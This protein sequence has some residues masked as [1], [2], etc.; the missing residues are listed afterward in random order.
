MCK[1]ICGFPGV[2]KT[3]FYE[4][5]KHKLKIL[6]LDS[7]QFDKSNFP[8]NYI[9]ELKNAINNYDIIMISTH[10]EVLDALNNENIKFVSIVP[11]KNNLENYKNMYIKRGNT[12]EFIN[13]IE[14]NW[15]SFIES[16]TEH[17]NNVIELKNGQYLEDV[18]LN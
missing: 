12:K 18:L 1:I 13:K 17:S 4:N 6:D 2:G 3:T 10:K 5:N 14:S 9:N 11:N 7:C 8:K 15:Y 16:V